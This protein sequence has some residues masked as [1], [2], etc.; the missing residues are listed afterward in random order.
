M[1]GDILRIPVDLVYRLVN[2][3]S[4]VSC[5]YPQH[6]TDEQSKHSCEINDIAAM[7]YL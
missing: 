4:G 6:N 5:W 2:D 1:S 3:S 7:E